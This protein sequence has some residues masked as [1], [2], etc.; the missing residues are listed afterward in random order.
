MRHRSTRPWSAQRLPVTKKENNNQEI[1]IINNIEMQLLKTK[2][3]TYHFLFA[4]GRLI[5]N[6]HQLIIAST[7]SK[8]SFFSKDIYRIELVCDNKI[9]HVQSVL[10]FANL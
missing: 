5:T 9:I 3:F 2:Y 6:L 10:F 8:K 1:N 7:A 4:N